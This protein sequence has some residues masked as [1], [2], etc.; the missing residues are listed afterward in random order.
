MAEKCGRLLTVGQVAKL[1]GVTIR[2]LHHYERVGL[3]VPGCR[4][5]AGYRLYADV[6]CDRLSQ[7][8]YYREL[9]FP[10]D[11][12]R[13]MLD[14]RS[15]DS[16][17]HMRRQ[18]QLLTSRIQR[19]QTMVAAIE[20]E[21]EAHMTGYRLT[22]EEKLEVFGDFDPDN[23]VEEAS[24]RWGETDAWNQSRQRT[25]DYTKA[26]WLAIQ[27]DSASIN[28]QF[29]S[30]MHSGEPGDGALA[31]DAAEAHRQHLSRWFYDCDYDMHRG[32]AEMYVADSRFTE[33]IDATAPGLAAYLREAILA[34]TNR[35]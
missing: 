35:A 30:L 2:T 1:A 24:Q 28:Q 22:P 17:A 15:S 18:H 25:A 34:N 19:I 27:A 21:M 23:Y 6:D 12:M 3:L 10:L 8:L 26:D 31:M 16:A 4:S 29:I 13:T 20:R 9:G 5:A 7:I 11:D 32:L 33:N 14:D